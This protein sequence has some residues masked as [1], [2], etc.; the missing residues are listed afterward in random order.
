ME[1]THKEHKKPHKRTLDGKV[2]SRNMQKTAVVLVKKKVLHPLY[3]KYYT[4]RKRY[5]VHDPEE[6]CSTGDQVRIIQCRP[7]S[8]EKKWRL[9]SILSK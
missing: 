4:R 6:K 9:E 3:K 7:V 8:S 1:E 2:V 5:K